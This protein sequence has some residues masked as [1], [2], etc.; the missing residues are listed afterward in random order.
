MAAIDDLNTAVAALQAEDVL[1]LAGLASRQA[2][3]A[4]PR[5]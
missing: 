1:V 4:T 5:D 2:H 3:V